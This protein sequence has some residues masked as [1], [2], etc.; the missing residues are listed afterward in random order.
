[1]EWQRE[2]ACTDEDPELFF[3][4]SNLGPGADQ[5]ARARRVCERCPVAQACLDWAVR[6]GQRTGV[7]GGVPA[8]QRRSVRH[9]ADRARTAG[10][11]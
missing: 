1:M 9:G 7:W 5:V 3:P 10:A 11:R 8:T 6:T 4:V 2:A